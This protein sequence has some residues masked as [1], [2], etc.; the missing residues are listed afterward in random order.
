[1]DFRGL[2]FALT[3]SGIDFLT[4][5]S[6][7]PHVLDILMLGLEIKYDMSCHGTCDD[8]IGILFTFLI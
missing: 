7:V 3:W 5:L 4:E 8:M 1:M 2:S 6:I